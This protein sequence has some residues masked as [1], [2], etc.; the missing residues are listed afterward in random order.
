MRLRHLGSDQEPPADRRH[1]VPLHLLRLQQGPGPLLQGRLHP[2]GG[3][4]GSARRDHR[5][6]GHQRAGDAGQAR[7]GGAPL[8]V[9]RAAGA[10]GEAGGGKR[11]R[12]DRHQAL[13]PVHHQAG[14]HHRPERAAGVPEKQAILS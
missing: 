1:R 13:R 2:R 11:R 9:L 3:A 4:G 6:G 14:E 5:A 10:R 12:R 7:G 8:P